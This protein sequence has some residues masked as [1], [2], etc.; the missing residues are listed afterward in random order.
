MSKIIKMGNPQLREESSPIKEKDF[1]SAWLKSLVQEL[2]TVLAEE[3][4]VGIAAPQIGEQYQL[5]AFGTAYSKHRKAA[6]PIPDSVLINPTIELLDNELISEYEGC[7]SVGEI[8]AK[9]D[10]YKKIRY[11]GFDIYGNLICKEAEGLEAR[12]VQ[13]ETDHLNGIL[14]VDRITDTR[15]MSLYSEFF[16]R[17]SL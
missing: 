13:H 10:R 1:G 12:I 8:M 6:I 4:G 3:G 16:K 15:S 11:T 7:L 5:F 9:V 17:Q 2:F 14:F